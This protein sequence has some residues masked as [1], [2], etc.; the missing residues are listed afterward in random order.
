M[1]NGISIMLMVLLIILIGL[2]V[3]LGRDLVFDLI[4][5]FGVGTAMLTGLVSL[6]LGSLLTIR[7][8]GRRM[9]LLGGSGLLMTGIALILFPNL[10]ARVLITAGGVMT[11][12]AGCLVILFALTLRQ[13]TGHP[14]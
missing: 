7:G 8:W 11:A 10:A 13:E 14:L 6:F 1:R 3:F 2:F 5:Y 12:L 9:I 4:I